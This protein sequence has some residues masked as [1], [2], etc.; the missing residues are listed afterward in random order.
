MGSLWRCGH[1]NAQLDYS[2][3]TIAIIEACSRS[4]SR[5]ETMGCKSFTQLE[6]QQ[7][8]YAGEYDDLCWYFLTF[9]VVTAM[10][11]KPMAVILSSY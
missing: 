8:Q 3:P 2:S 9:Y 11:T 4:E 6:S 5:H 1:I 7:T 10:A